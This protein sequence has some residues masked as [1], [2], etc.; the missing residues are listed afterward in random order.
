MSTHPI[1]VIGGGPIG[2]A[3]AAH[4]AERGEPFVLVE[5][6][7]RVGASVRAWGH[8]QLFSPWQ[9]VID[10]AARALLERA[11]W[12]EPKLD[13]YPT[14]DDLVADY[15]EPLA[16][17]PAIAPHLRFG[18][19]VSKV[20]RAG[21]DELVSQ[22]CGELPFDL[23]IETA[24]GRT[25]LRARAVIDASGTWTRPNP[26]GA[27]GLPVDGEVEATDRIT[28]RIPDALGRDRGRYAGRSTVVVGSGHSAFNALLD[29][30]ALAGQAPGTE[31]IWAIRRPLSAT[32]FGGGVDDALPQR[33][34]LGLAVRRLVDDGR[35]RIEQ[36]LRTTAVQ[37]QGDRVVLEGVDHLGVARQVGPVDEVVALTGFRPDLSLTS[38]LRLDLD[39]AV[40][41]PSA[42]APLIDPNLHSCGTVPPHGAAELGHPE[43]GFYTV[44]MKAYGRAPTFL[45]LT[46]YEQ[47]RSVVAELV[48]DHAAAADVRLVLPET[49]V[50]GGSGVRSEPVGVAGT[51]TDGR[52]PLPQ[53][54]GSGCC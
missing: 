6:G 2:L 15:L 11:G 12:H 34:A 14:G 18:H 38:E 29:L 4:L 51:G 44:G 54:A 28:H 32:L 25:R 5:A 3:A 45:M 23:L 20:T 13:A 40:E 24:S 41:A 42:L 8:V 7:E 22:G 39:P 43:S 9:Y 16:S 37:R 36:D 19:R 50:C 47:V 33:G 21:A 10:P 35:I 30:A 26:L 52:Q 49:G 31:V 48:G 46:G 1:A 17:D 53:A 27:D